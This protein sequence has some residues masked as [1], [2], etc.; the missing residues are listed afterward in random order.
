MG[1]CNP[2]IPTHLL[3]SI[4]SATGLK[5]VVKL[6]MNAEYLNLADLEP[7][8]Y[9]LENSVL[10]FKRT[11]FTIYLWTVHAVRCDMHKY[12]L[13]RIIGLRIKF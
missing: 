1:L 4:G 9:L 13:K 5:E 12:L 8:V 6:H 10:Q 2:L 3:K 7:M 11:N